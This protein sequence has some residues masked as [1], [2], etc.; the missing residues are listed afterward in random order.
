M[1]VFSEAKFH[2][3]VAKDTFVGR[4]GQDLCT[5]VSLSP[6]SS[7]LLHAGA[8]D[9]DDY[10]PPVVTFCTLRRDEEVCDDQVFSTAR[11]V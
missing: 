5:Y 9:L 1:F 8:E 2:P 7:V 4:L 11:F 6:A 10:H 3:G